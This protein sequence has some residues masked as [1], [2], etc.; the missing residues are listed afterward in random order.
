MRIFIYDALAL[1]IPRFY[2]GVNK[3]SFSMRFPEGKRPCEVPF[4]LLQSF[5]LCIYPFT[6]GCD[7]KAEKRRKYNVQ[8]NRYRK[9]GMRCQKNHRKGE[10]TR[11][12]LLLAGFLGG[13]DKGL[14]Y[15]ELFLI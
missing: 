4:N 14:F 7:Y 10:T 15:Y 6:G 13:L 9:A 3:K 11:L 12:S 1:L 5:L 8:N 2:R